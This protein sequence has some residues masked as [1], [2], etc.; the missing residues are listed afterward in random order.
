MI[1]TRLIALAAGLV[2]AGLAFQA[3]EYSTLDWLTLRR[4]RVEERRAVRDLE[5]WRALSSEVNLVAGA[6]RVQGGEAGVLYR[7]PQRPYWVRLSYRVDD[8]VVRAGGSE[9]LEAVSL[10]IGVGSW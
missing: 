3:G 8:A 5:L 4:Q 9:T 1:R 2:L 7:P 10:A 6:G